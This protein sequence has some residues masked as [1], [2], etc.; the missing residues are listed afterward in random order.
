[1]APSTV[2]FLHIPKTAGTTFRG[3]LERAYRPAQMREIYGDIP[4]AITSF[5]S[6]PKA[7]RKQIRCLLGHFEFGLHTDLPQ[8]AS[9]VTFLRDPIDRIISHY[10][11]VRRSPGHYLHDT[12]VSEEVAL[13]DYVHLAD[14]LSNGQTQ[15]IAGGAQED[16]PETWLKAAKRNL[17]EH[18]AVV[19]ITERFDASLALMARRLE[20]GAVYYRVR[21]ATRKRPR[22]A[23]LDSQTLDVLKRHNRVD[24]ELYAFANAL[25]DAQVEN[26]GASLQRD[27]ART[28]LRST[29]FSYYDRLRTKARSLTRS[30]LPS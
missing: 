16:A 29:A 10:Y 17:R 23:D 3:I 6:L 26:T 4:E 20:W 19:G 18:F 2:I 27:I 7:E 28:H 14:E 21:N 30:L 22:K 15:M 5:Q 24:C 1:M 25:L 12:V 8:P 13:K 9:Y 11:Y